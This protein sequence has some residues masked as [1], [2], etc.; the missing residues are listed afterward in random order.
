MSAFKEQKKVVFLNGPPKCGKDTIATHLVPYF[1]F[2]KMKQAAPLK[3]AVAGL[4]DMTVEAVE[5]HKDAEFQILR[6]EQRG[7]D[8][9]HGTPSYDYGP[10]DTIRGLL[11]HISEKLL[12]PLYGNT[13]FGRIAA[14]ELQRSSYSLIIITDTGFDDECDPIIRAVGKSNTILLRIHRANCTFEG[15][16]RSYLG[17]IAGKNIDISNDGTIPECIFRCAAAIRNHFG[18]TLLKELEL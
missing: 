9:S 12:K 7:P 4:L 10:P 15:D 8:G 17:D 18:L 13:F 16:S 5:R 2:Q 3:R 11:I 6:H 1:A 14:R